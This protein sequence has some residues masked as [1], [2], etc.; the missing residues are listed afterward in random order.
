[1]ELKYLATFQA[2]VTYGGFSKAAEALHYTQSTITFQMRQLE[3]ELA[4][5]L[6][7]KRGRRMLL[8]RA[9]EQLIPYANEVLAAA[10]KLRG[11]QDTLGELRGDLRVA[12][13]ETLLCYRLPPVLKRFQARA[14]HARLFLRSMNCCEIRDAL[15]AGSIDL[16][17]F[18][19]EVGALDGLSVEPVGE[20]ALT[21]VASPRVKAAF[22]D[23]VT[24]GQRLAV[25]FI[26]DEPNC[27]FRQ[28]FEAYLKERDITL[29]HTIEL[30]SIPTIKN[31]VKSDVGVSY[32]P[33]FAVRQELETGE[34]CAIRTG[35]DG[36]TITAVCGVHQ[37]RWRSPLIRLF[38]ELVTEA[39][40]ADEK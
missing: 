11:F 32:L 26:I 16:G 6:F 31:L 36:R 28:M 35:L 2:I 7:E 9:G 18:Y 24:P 23:F 15:R 19:R 5:P 8:T 27:I 17:V 3:R 39:R 30:L 37:S 22:P 38:W 40:A 13:G 12:V 20:F 29:G 14:P 25:P 10:E 1:M 21:L 4:A 33:A 34:L